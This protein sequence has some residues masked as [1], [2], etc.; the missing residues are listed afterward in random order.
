MNNVTIICPYVFEEEVTALKNSC[1]LLDVDVIFEEDTARIG[2]DLMYQKL[3]NKAVPNDV[4]ILHSDMSFLNSAEEWLSELLRYVAKYPEAGM[5]GCKLLYPIN[6]NGKFYVQCAGGKITKGLPDHFGSGIDLLQ[7]KS[8][9]EPEVD[10][11][12]YDNVREVAWT[13]FGGLYI[14][15]ELLSAV[16]ELDPQFEW[17]Y[18]RDVDYC[19]ESRKLGWKIYQVPVPLFHFESKDTK[20][21]KTQYHIDAESRNLQKLKNKWTGSSLYETINTIIND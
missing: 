17:T 1:L 14:R 5:L 16:G 9:K 4:I 21:I 8:W 19:L 2:C 15:R 11:G 12:Q 18:F 10:I 6:T 3:W 7:S 20:R 13:T